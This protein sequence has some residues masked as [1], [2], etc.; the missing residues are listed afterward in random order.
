VSGQGA[1]YVDRR[2]GQL[3][4]DPIYAAAFM[5][6]CYNA[7]AGKTLTRSILNRWFASAL[8]GWY[9]KQPWTRSKIAPFAAAMQVNLDE[10]DGDLAQFRSFNE[11]ICR[12]IDLSKRAID[13]D[14]RTFISPV[15]GRLLAYREVAADRTFQIKSGEFDLRRLLA[16]EDLSRR[17]Q[18]GSVVILR[19]YLAD[20][21]HFHFPDSGVPGE[22]RIVPGRYFAVSP[23][24]RQ[25]AVPFYGENRR[26][27][28]LFDS[29][30][31]GRVALIEIGAFTVGSIQQTFV[32][33]VRVS[34]GDPK[35]YFELGASVVVLVLQRGAI[36][37]DED[38]C[39]NTEAG[40]ETF[41]RLGE[42]IGRV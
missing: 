39:R 29:D 24:S 7:R 22:P 31:F 21:H 9:Y 10:L 8:Y 34:K 25:W 18:G 11:F 13:P 27:I 32:P 1:A 35:G 16:D 5:D 33:H 42:R 38:L 20:Y 19:L 36:Q 17:Y 15:D 26:T 40:L 2:D 14:P 3:K 4:R 30:V 6:W 12:R 37:L 41:V 28:T 23:Y